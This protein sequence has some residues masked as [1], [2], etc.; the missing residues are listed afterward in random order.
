MVN[1]TI[2]Q[3]LQDLW[4]LKFQ[5]IAVQNGIVITT[6][7]GP[8]HTVIATANIAFIAMSTGITSAL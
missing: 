4:K 1:G 5:N 7:F 8:L 2:S 3:K 6:Y